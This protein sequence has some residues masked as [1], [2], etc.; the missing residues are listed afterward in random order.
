MAVRLQR[1]LARGSQKA[2]SLLDSP[3]K[4]RAVFA[5]VTRFSM[6]RILQEMSR[7]NQRHRLASW[8]YNFQKKWMQ[9]VMKAN[10]FC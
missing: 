1:R 2:G 9:K 3:P 10:A 6:Q 4:S 7:Q 5:F 8:A